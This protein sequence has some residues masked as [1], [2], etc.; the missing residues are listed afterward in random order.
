M[1]FIT[2]TVVSLAATSNKIVK[3]PQINRLYS[4]WGGGGCYISDCFNLEIVSLISSSSYNIL[5]SLAPC[6]GTNRPTLSVLFKYKY[7]LYIDLQ[8]NWSNSTLSCIHKIIQ[9]HSIVDKDHFLV[10]LLH[11]RSQNRL[12]S[13]FVINKMMSYLGYNDCSKEL[14]YIGQGPEISVTCSSYLGQTG[15]SVLCS[16]F[17]I[18]HIS[19]MNISKWLLYKN[20]SILYIHDRAKRVKVTNNCFFYSM[21]SQT[22]TWLQVILQLFHSHLCTKITESC[23]HQHKT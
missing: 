19:T 17:K 2:Q 23:Y 3:H 15:Q 11:M 21:K 6:H 1:S 10:I 9:F 12:D 5:L 4:Y 8:G 14:Q 13:V 20:D 18:S 7:C 16:L 22:A